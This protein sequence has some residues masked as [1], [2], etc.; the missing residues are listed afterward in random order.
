MKLRLKGHIVQRSA[1]LWAEL[2]VLK[3]SLDR[4]LLQWVI[5]GCVV[6]A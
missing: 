1:K 2:L 6:I 3:D 4:V 5:Q